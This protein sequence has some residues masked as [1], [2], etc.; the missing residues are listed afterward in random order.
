[1]LYN[2]QY[3]MTLSFQTHCLTITKNTEYNRAFFRNRIALER[4]DYIFSTLKDIFYAW[5]LE[6]FH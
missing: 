3:R 1:M 4:L 2:S 6:R 5:F